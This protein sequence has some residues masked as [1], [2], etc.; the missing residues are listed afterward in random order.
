VTIV[1]TKGSKGEGSVVVK[2]KVVFADHEANQGTLTL[3]QKLEQCCIAFV[4]DFI[5]SYIVV[6]F[7]GQ[8]LR[9]GDRK[10]C[11]K[12]CLLRVLQ[13]RRFSYNIYS[14]LS[15][16]LVSLPLDPTLLYS[17]LLYSILF[18]SIL[19]GLKFT[20]QGALYNAL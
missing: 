15:H 2:S 17:T 7:A 16:A 9:L 10:C 6:I 12:V 4:E 8:D 3:Y 19:F 18:S 5:L 13:Q 14:L 11:A 20:V 1:S